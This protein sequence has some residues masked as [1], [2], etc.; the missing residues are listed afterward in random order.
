MSLYTPDRV[1]WKR[2]KAIDQRLL[3]AW[4]PT[5]ER[6]QIFR[7]SPARS[8]QGQHI[9]QDAEGNDKRASLF[10]NVQVP[11]HV[12]TVK[13]PFDAPPEDAAAYIPLDDRTIRRLDEIDSWRL[14]RHTK[15]ADNLQEVMDKLEAGDQKAKDWEMSELSGEM[16]DD[17]ARVKK[18]EW[19]V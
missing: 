2:L 13:C 10:V 8:Y 5:I 9:L 12:L 16:A 6:W 15:P 1:F 19:E 17:M 14:N 3:V 18:S 7:T 4:N 11:K